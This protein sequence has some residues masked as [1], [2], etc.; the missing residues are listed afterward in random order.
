MG[1]SEYERAK[2]LREANRG[3]S[4]FVGPRSNELVHLAESTLSFQF[5]P[6]YRRFLLELGAGNFGPA[7]F[8]GIIDDDFENSSV[9]DGVWFT[10][11]ERRE[12]RL[13]S[14]L[15]V[16]GDTGTGS[17]YCLETRRD[18][19]EGAVVVVDPGGD[20]LAREIV[21]IDFGVFFLNRI[22]EVLGS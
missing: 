9:P 1:V 19:S 18:G 7:E 13:S 14:D 5:P 4:R 15:M 12:R 2:G 11:S 6:T 20:P 8:Y 3:R 16:I 21:A 17:L 22:N 10:L